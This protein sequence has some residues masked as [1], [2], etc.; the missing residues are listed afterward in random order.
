MKYQHFYRLIGII[1]MGMLLA[2][3]VPWAEFTVEPTPVVAGK[4]ATFDASTSLISEKEHGQVTYAWDFGD[5]TAQGSGKIVTHT[6]ATQGTYNV[7]LTLT[8]SK[9]EG[10][11]K[12]KSKAKTGT[13][14]KAIQVASA[15]TEGGVSV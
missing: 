2:A 12:D 6:F 9:S 10:N 3:C 4:S 5:G 11:N 8:P 15:T 14:T 7:T 13:V 1:F